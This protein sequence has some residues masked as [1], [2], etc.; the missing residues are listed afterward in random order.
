ME[1]PLPPRL[2]QGI[3]SIHLRHSWT[4]P[5]K[6]WSYPSK[7]IVGSVR[8]VITPRTPPRDEHR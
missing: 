4:S 8:E 5:P 2:S 7:M 1:K 3:G 6:E